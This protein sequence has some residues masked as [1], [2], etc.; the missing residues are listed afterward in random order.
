[1]RDDKTLPA[2]DAAG[3]SRVLT[4]A[5]TTFAKANFAKTNFD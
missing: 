1:L 4:F 3:R 5:K 2:R